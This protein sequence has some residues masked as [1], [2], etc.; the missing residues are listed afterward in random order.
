MKLSLIILFT[1]L[2]QLSYSQ[3]AEVKH[4]HNFENTS[5]NKMIINYLG[6]LVVIRDAAKP[7]FSIY[8]TA[9]FQIKS[10]ISPSDNLHGD[11]IDV[12]YDLTA[13]RDSGY[14]VCGRIPLNG[15]S[16]GTPVIY[17]FNDSA[18]VN[19]VYKGE[20]FGSHQ[21]GYYPVFKNVIMRSDGHIIAL[22]QYT[23][24]SN[25]DDTTQKS[26]LF[27]FD[28][29]LSLIG[30][31]T[32]RSNHSLKMVYNSK[33]EKLLFFGFENG[34][35]TTLTRYPY[36]SVLD[37]FTFKTEFEKILFEVRGISDCILS[38][39][40]IIVSLWT[41]PNDA[42]LLS[43]DLNNGNLLNTLSFSNYA[44]DYS[45]TALDKRS[46]GTYAV[47]VLER[48]TSFNT[49]K[50]YKSEMIILN[51][52]LRVLTKIEPLDSTGWAGGVWNF[53]NVDDTYFFSQYRILTG[54]QR[55]EVLSRVDVSQ[56]TNILK[57]EKKNDWN[58]YPNPSSGI[59]QIEAP[60]EYKRENCEV[61]I[62]SVSGLLMR[63]DK[64]KDEIDISTLPVGLYYLSVFDKSG[65]VNTSKFSK[66]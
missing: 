29:S 66:Q 42:K 58:L 44:T 49:T 65:L 59:I 26:V 9:A 11:P 5:F 17:W 47:F 33:Q 54:V 62:Y 64:L 4:L 16:I 25:A 8:D 39:Q 36:F 30:M 56:I 46:N 14:L 6:D 61:R 34:I 27:E 10:E 38:N 19:V 28:S 43:F 48:D 63:S 7:I 57:A 2:F 20:V 45:I 12:F 37:A 13:H 22:Y 52:D 24:I 60:K 41:H 3:L 53:Y 55:A 31:D 50:P 18:Q 32:I 40:E 35:D 21:T 1:F 15:S 23:W 51:T